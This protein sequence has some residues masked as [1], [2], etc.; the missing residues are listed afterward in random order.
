MDASASTRSELGEI[1]NAAMAFV[2]QLRPID[3]ILIIA[4]DNDL[5]LVAKATSDRN[6][7]YQAIRNIRSGD[8]TRLYDTVDIALNHYFGHTASRKAIILFT[9]GRDTASHEAS[10]ETTLRDAEASG[11]LIYSI[12][13]SPPSMDWMSP[14]PKI[15]LSRLEIGRAHV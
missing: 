10:F 8:G 4:F 15:Y 14:V 3:R 13:Y 1:Q 2:N 12:M 11:T 7:L 9:D 5:K 6:K